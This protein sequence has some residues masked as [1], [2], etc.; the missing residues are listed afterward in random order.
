MTFK[1]LLRDFVIASYET[2]SYIVFSMPRHKL[3]FNPLKRL[4]LRL[5]GAKVGS[6]VTFYPGIKISPGKNIELGDHVDL[7]WRV[8]ITTRGGVKIGNRTLIGYGTQILS[9]N[10][11]VPYDKGKIFYSGHE[12]K[13]IL[14]EQDVW[15]GANC[16]ILAGVIIGEGSIVAAGSVV[17]KDIKPFTVVGGVPAKLIKTRD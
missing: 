12:A 17:T 8:L 16:I 7:A 10:H 11:K 14:I 4:F 2:V 5:H 6:F 3:L 13:P 9:S 1:Q 15:I